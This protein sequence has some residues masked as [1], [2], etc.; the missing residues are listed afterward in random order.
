[1]D[2]HGK[3]A[4]LIPF[5]HFNSMSI[6]WNQ[7]KTNHAETSPP[8]FRE[9]F[10]MFPQD[11]SPCFASS[12]VGSS[13]GVPQ[14]MRRRPCKRSTQ[15][16]S[17][18]STASMAHISGG[19]NWKMP[20][21]RFRWIRH[22]SGSPCF[23]TSKNGTSWKQGVPFLLI[24]LAE[25]D[26]IPPATLDG[27]AAHFF[28]SKIWLKHLLFF[29]GYSSMARYIVHVWNCDGFP[30][31]SRGFRTSVEL[32]ARGCRSLD[33]GDQGSH[34]HRCPALE[35][36]TWREHV[37][38]LAMF[39]LRALQCISYIPHMFIHSPISEVTNSRILKTLLNLPCKL[40]VAP[41]KPPSGPYSSKKL[42]ALKRFGKVVST[43][44]S[45]QP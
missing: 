40:A 11:N 37:I 44:G 45:D 6:C 34:Q 1:M 22:I 8:K 2:L 10:E 41:G 23:R 3:F 39:L 9:T 20:E 19:M 42:R 30:L 29:Y 12:L 16:F 24:G 33:P 21:E 18:T 43:L 35:D 25:S 5:L 32:V 26:Y 14:W 7:K 27:C 15:P 36:E 28:G 31:P 13:D 4:H 38:C 17:A